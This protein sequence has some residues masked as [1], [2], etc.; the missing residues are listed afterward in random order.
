[1]LRVYLDQNKWIDLAR[2]ATGHKQ[3]ERF[4]EALTA[5]RAAS[6]SGV[7]SFPLDIYRHLETGKRADARSGIDLADLI[8]EISKQHALARPHTLLPAE[9]D[10]ALQ[11]RFG[12]PN[13]PRAAEVFRVGIRHITDGG[14]TLPDFESDRLRGS[15]AGLSTMELTQVERI[16]KELAERELLRGRPKATQGSRY[17]PIKHRTRSTV[18]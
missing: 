14:V 11:R 1:M 7:A 12:L 3:G 17:R 16:F 18:C 6:T 4:V 9:I 2:A 5:V 10:Q 13:T 15:G 8:H